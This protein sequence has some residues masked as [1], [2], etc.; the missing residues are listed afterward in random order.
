MRCKAINAELQRCVEQI[1]TAFNASP[2]AK[3]KRREIKNPEDVQTLKQLKKALKDEHTGFYG[4][5]SPRSKQFVFGIQEESKT[6][7]GEKAKKRLGKHWK[8][9]F[10]VR[11]IRYRNAVDFNDGLRRKSDE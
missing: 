2:N 11:K 7:V 6:A 5:F 9:D 1:R 10:E 4:L 8:Y 3:R